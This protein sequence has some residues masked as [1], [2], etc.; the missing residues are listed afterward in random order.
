M[1]AHQRYGDATNQPNHI[2]QVKREDWTLAA[3]NYSRAFLAHDDADGDEAEN[4]A[5]RVRVAVDQESSRRRIVS[6][7]R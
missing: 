4:D 1:V 3:H 2:I 5:R 7:P 6:P